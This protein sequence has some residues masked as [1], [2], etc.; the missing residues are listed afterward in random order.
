M[1]SKSKQYFISIIV[2]SK[3]LN[4]KDKDIL[5]KRLQGMTLH[6]IGRRYKLSAERIRQIEEE[7]L[8]KLGKKISQLLL[9]D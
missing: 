8:A 1:T 2:N 3:S 6:R 9:F 7:A 4:K 5:V